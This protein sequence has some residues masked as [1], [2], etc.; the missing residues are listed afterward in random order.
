MEKI[1]KIIHVDLD[2]F[3]AQVE[4]LDHPELKKKPFAVG[5]SYSGKGVVCTS[6]YVAR[7]F[8]VKSAMPSFMAM[9]RCPQIVF[10][11]P[12]F[13]K[14]TEKSREIFEIF[15]KYTDKIQKLSLDEAYLDVTDCRFF[16][17]DAVKIAKAIR[18]E[19]FSKTGLTASAGVSY[20]KLLAKI[21]SDL[22]K[23]D[24]LA[25]LRPEN[26]EANIRHFP[27]QKIQ[28]IGKVTAKKFFARGINTFGDLQ[29]LTKAELVN[30]HGDYGVSL[31]NFC[32]GID[33]REVNPR[34]IRKSLSVENTFFENLQKSEEMIF[35]LNHTYDEL[36][37]RLEKHQDKTIKNLV[38]KLKYHDFQTS[39]V[40]AALDF[41]ED[42][43]KELFLRRWHE[44]PEPIRLL[45]LGVK[46]Q[47][48]MTAARQLEFSF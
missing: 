26:I 16:Q 10:L 38:V 40:E 20:N 41:K 39:T 42:S 34:R 23:P 18:K 31:Y 33:H 8:G 35:K 25:V 1:K 47:T 5:G 46:F 36:K 21:G 9:K 37:D 48:R 13:Y 44:R 7:E 3:Y 2:Y 29:K 12:N 17:N 43:F 45:G 15:S 11:R 22:F 14:Y 27:I 30:W 28:G 24:G 4:E 32:R 19:I 6:N